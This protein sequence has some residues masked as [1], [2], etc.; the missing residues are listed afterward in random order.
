MPGTTSPQNFV[1]DNASNILRWNCG[2]SRQRPSSATAPWNVPASS[3]CDTIFRTLQ[4]LPAGFFKRVSQT[5]RPVLKCTSHM[6][7]EKDSSH[8]PRFFCFRIFFSGR[9]GKGVSWTNR[10]FFFAAVSCCFIGTASCD[11]LTIDRTF[12][13]RSGRAPKQTK[14][15]NYTISTTAKINK[16][17]MGQNLLWL[18]QKVL[19][20]NKWFG[21][22][23]QEH[24]SQKSRTS[25]VQS[26]VR[27][28]F[29]LRC[30]FSFHV[31]FLCFLRLT[32]RK[33]DTNSTNYTNIRKLCMKPCEPAEAS[34]TNQPALE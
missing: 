18:A 5:L 26:R 24:R 9:S 19:N 10:W 2:E 16:I 28:A 12:I 13:I 4:R 11:C 29:R 21:C 25:C 14:D 6:A 32:H 8:T 30:H 3:N 20:C 33:G 17:P 7:S 23:V 31:D 22:I 15:M 1:D 27:L 34:Q